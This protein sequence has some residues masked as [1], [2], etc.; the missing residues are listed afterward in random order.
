MSS[1]ITVT[2]NFNLKNINLDL[3]KELNTAGQII[4]KDHFQRLEKGQGVSGSA[5]KSLSPKTVKAKGHSKILVDSGKM[6]NLV[7]DKATK[8]K[9]ITEIHP[10]RSQTYPNSNVTMSDV[11]AFHQEG[12]G[13][14]PKREW[15][16]ISKGA[17]SDIM[18]MMEMKI[19]REIK[20]A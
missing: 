1:A 6:R 4:R 11:G 15:F 5:M 12:A 20:S 8:A 16:G 7:I 10:G 18:R 17:E 9:Q 19:D 2:R 14:L 3:H 13:S